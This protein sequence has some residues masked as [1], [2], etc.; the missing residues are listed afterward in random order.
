[1]RSGKARPSRELAAAID[2]HL[3]A[4]GALAALA[5][6]RTRR[7]GGRGRDR[8]PRAG[9][10]RRGVRRR[11]R[12]L[13]ADRARRRRHGDRLSP[14]RPAELLRR[15]RAHLGYA[16]SCSTAGPRSRSGGGCW[17]PAGWL[18]L[19]AATVLIDLDDDPPAVA[20]LRTAE[21][22]ARE[23]GHAEI[24]AWVLETRAWIEVTAGRYRDAVTLAQGGQQVAPR[25]GSAFIQATA[26]EG[27]AWARLGDQAR[28]TAALAA[29]DALVASLPSPTSPSTTT[30]TTRRRPRPTW[31]PP[32]HGSATLPP[33]R[34]RATSSAASRRPR[35]GRRATAAPLRPAWISP[36][37]RG[38]GKHDE[39][40]GTALQAVTSGYLVPSN[41]W[42]AREVITAV[43]PAASP[44]RASWPTPTGPRSRPGRARSQAN[45][46]PAG[47]AR[48]H[49]CQRVTPRQAS[50]A[51]RRSRP[52]RRRPP[53]FP[54]PRPRPP[55]TAAGR[56]VCTFVHLA[57][58]PT[59]PK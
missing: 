59:G 27:R 34:W 54:C 6:R 12:H 29:M 15:V 42:R 18:S 40:S 31:S 10:P 23:T 4:G 9:A 39:A 2:A 11:R 53:A 49:V 19:L 24:T 38:Q 36:R 1:M 50:P 35:T 14:H 55:P 58:P 20:Y 22:L 8:R 56:P 52:E 43:R 17:C 57:G 46:A 26:Q 33:S 51:G 25:D 45:D 41:Y 3:D 32:C 28:T 13:R 7:P 44:R 16:T 30:G 37:P 48:N 5:P 21:Q 47:Y